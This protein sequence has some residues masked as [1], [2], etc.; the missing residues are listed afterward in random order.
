[1]TRSSHEKHRKSDRLTIVEG[2]TNV[3]W[4]R[5]GEHHVIVLFM[6][7]NAGQYGVVNPLLSVN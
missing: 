1:M 4:I 3:D 7:E 2:L 6:P 5:H